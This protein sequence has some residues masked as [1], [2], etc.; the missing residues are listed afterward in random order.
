MTDYAAPEQCSRWT[1]K[2]WTDYWK[3]F[4]HYAQV[5]QLYEAGEHLQAVATKSWQIAPPDVTVSRSAYFL[6]N[7]L[8]R[9]TGMAYTD[10]PARDMAG[11]ISKVQKETRAF[12][13]KDAWLID[14]GLYARQK[15][16]DLFSRTAIPRWSRFLPRVRI[17]MEVE[18][19]AIYSSY[20]GNEYFALWLTDDC[21][22]YPLA[23]D[24]GIPVTTTRPTWAHIPEY[25]RLLGMAPVRTNGALLRTAVVIDDTGQNA[26]KQARF[27]ANINRLASNFPAPPHP[28]VFILRRASGKARIMHNELETAE[29]LRTK[30]GF[31]VVDATKDDVRTILANCVGAQVIAG[32][33]G[34]QLFHGIMALAPG[35]SVLALQPPDRF[36]PVIKRTTDPDNQN[37]GFVVGNAMAGGFTVDL[38]EVERTLDLFPPP[39]AP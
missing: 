2:A 16:F 10:N 3:A 13:L 27:R 14:S 26:H 21:S 15:R 35:G 17:E 4:K 20:D 23:R 19:A 18:S 24:A 9:I 22:N 11:G 32:I 8:E 36:S 12:L 33:E 34:S 7:Q 37:Y 30:R 39:T 38:D 1:Y 6:P 31:R 28:G 29:Y 25:E 5:H